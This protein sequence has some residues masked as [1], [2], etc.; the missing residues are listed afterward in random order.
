MI[1]ARG[2]AVTNV[3]QEDQRRV[4]EGC[5]HGPDFGSCFVCVGKPL[6]TLRP[7]LSLIV[8][9]LAVL[10]PAGVY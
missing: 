5:N 6:R 3:L 8:I 1:L 2:A 4:L 10:E 9:E 7:L